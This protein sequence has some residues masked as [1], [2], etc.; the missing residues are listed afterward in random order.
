MQFIGCTILNV[1]VQSC[2]LIPHILVY[3]SMI[4]SRSDVIPEIRRGTSFFCEIIQ[5]EYEMILSLRFYG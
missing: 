1:K 2:K 5:Q 3:N 4:S